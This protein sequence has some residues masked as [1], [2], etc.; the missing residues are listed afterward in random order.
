MDQTQ[1]AILERVRSLNTWKR[2]GERAPHKPRPFSETMVPRV[3]LFTR[4][5]RFGTFRVTASGK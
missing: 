1:A 2:G 5:I 4:N 3:P